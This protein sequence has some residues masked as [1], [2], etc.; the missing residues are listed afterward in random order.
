MDRESVL[1]VVSAG[2]FQTMGIPMVH[3]RDFTSRDDENAPKA[4][5]VN[6]AMARYYFGTED[7]VGRTFH[8][9]SSDFPTSLTVV[10]LVQNAKYRSL[11][12]APVRMIYLPALQTP[13]PLGG[14]NIAIRTMND[15]QRMAD[16]LWNVAKS[17]SPYLRFGGFTTQEQLVDGTIAQERML[18]ELSGFFGLF[19][20]VLV[21]LG[22]YGLT[23]YQVSRRTAEIGVRIALGAQRRDVVWMVLKGSITLVVAGS[24][25]GLCAALFLGRLVESLLFGVRALDTV[26]LLATPA[27]LVGI[28]A[29][30]AYWPARRA[31][32]LDPMNSL[33]CE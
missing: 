25:L 19:A 16:M 13:G 29:A 21:C 2:F 8:L 12:E 31:A 6:D 3:G 17:E 22:L 27:M 18:A 10:G 33:R 20:A 30:A 11:K 23:A 15:P 32:R 9:E 4:A 14:A 7:P 24:A 1:L 26:T 5:V 28:G